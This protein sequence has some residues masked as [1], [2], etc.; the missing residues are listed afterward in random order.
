[1]IIAP[2]ND[3]DFFER[4]HTYLLLQRRPI[5]EHIDPLLPIQI[6]P[7]RQQ[8]PGQ[9]GID[10][11]LLPL[12]LRHALHEMDL[13]GLGH[14]VRHR[15]AP[16]TLPGHAAG[17]DHRTALGVG[18]E[19]RQC[20]GDEEFGPHDVRRPALEPFVLAHGVQVRE[21]GEFRPPGVGDDDVESAEGGDGG[22]DAALA[23][24]LL[25]CV[26]GDDGC[27]DVG[28]R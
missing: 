5:L 24:G 10:P 25:A 19:R 14:G 18:V 17:D 13:C 1:M 4:T 21:V 2:A 6:P 8:Q 12:R 11:Q 23:V 7:I 16:Q 3:Q 22:L 26:A 20:R 15:T 9:H 28:M 27:F